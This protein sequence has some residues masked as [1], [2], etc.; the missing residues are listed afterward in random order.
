MMS[1]RSR[2]K[3]AAGFS[4]AFLL[5]LIG[6]CD[7]KPGAEGGAGAPA[8]QAEETVNPSTAFLDM[9]DRQAAEA[10]KESPEFAT[11]LGVSEEIAGENYNA[12]LG[13]YGFE[14]DQR[15]REINE[16]YLQELRSV[17]RS[18]LS[19]TA[20]ITYDVLK[21]SYELGARRNE[22]P[23][24]GAVT[25][26]VGSPYSVT[27]ISG[28]HLYLPRLLLTQHPVDSKKNVEAYLSRLGEFSRVFDEVSQ[29][30]VSDAA[31]GV[32]PPAFAIDGAMTAIR[33]FTGATPEEN[34]LVSTLKEKMESLDSLTPEER[35]E[36][37]ARAR[38]LVSDVVYPAYAR[39]SATLE[40]LK[41]Q[42]GG[43]AGVWRLGE[44]G[45]AFYQLALNSY[46]A[47][48]MTGDEIHELGLSEVA[49][50]Q[51]EMD[52]IFKG[53]GMTEGSVADR[54]VALGARADMVYPNTDEGRAALLAELNE[55]I[56]D[57]MAKAPQ[58]FGAIPQQSVEVRRIPVYEQDSA[59]GGY[60][61]GPS[62]DG[63]RPGIYWINLKD[64]ADWPKHTLKTLTFHEA[65][66]GHHFQISLQRAIDD[67]PLI[68]NMMG[69]SEF[70]EGWALYAEQVASE[71]GMYADDPVGDLGRLQSE[72]FRAARLVTDSGLHTKHWTREQAIDYMVDTT[73]ETRASVTR[74][75]ERYSV[76]PGQACS[77]KLG[78][79]RINA[80]RK[81]AEEALGDKFDIREFHDQ[82]LLTGSMPMPVLEKKIRA[83]I[84]SKR[85]A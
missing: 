32:T 18:A 62:L 51:G 61:T 74:E 8:E 3:Y 43:D 75:V 67:L 37:A 12:R 34:P 36:F 2:F 53:M 27:Q 56:K 11:S 46:G 59:P 29:S 26:G 22:F 1:S 9:A 7:K 79:I 47:D 82:V 50:I 83:W 10:L 72:L 17:D 52:A 15:A 25:W 40:G 5:A 39:L 42:T 24:G 6:G 63:T 64:T 49:R 68:R 70:S 19:G 85:A 45:D 84:E 41:E 20:A 14:A 80:L 21:V 31:Q 71:M 54:F 48:G 69:F 28:P 58:W 4:A 38:D 66:P 33:V 60:Y 73:G 55:Q 57:L 44:E 30:L 81:E 77:Y 65:V 35:G 76:W 78:M 23:F 16:Q 13:D